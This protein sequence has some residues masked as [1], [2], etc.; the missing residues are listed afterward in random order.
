MSE[1][2]PDCYCTEEEAFGIDPYLIPI[3]GWVMVKRNADGAGGLGIKYLGTSDPAAEL[4]QERADNAALREEMSLLQEH[5]Y[6]PEAVEDLYERI[7]LLEQ[8]YALLWTFDVEP[9]FDAKGRYSER[10]A[11]EW[12]QLLSQAAALVPRPVSAPAPDGLEEE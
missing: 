1:I 5:W 6:S 10:K 7:R 4:D 3:E 9:T 11:E 2:K 8:A 12:K